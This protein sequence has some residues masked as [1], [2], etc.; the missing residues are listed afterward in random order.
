M[1]NIGKEQQ[2][3][4]MQVLEKVILHRPPVD[5]HPEREA[6]HCREAAVAQLCNPIGIRS[7]VHQVDQEGEG[8]DR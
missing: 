8:V 1:V 3:S 4:R 2:Q 7:E 5:V 6:D